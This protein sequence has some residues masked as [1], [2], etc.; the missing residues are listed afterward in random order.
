MEWFE[1][2]DKGVIS[3][4]PSSPI[5]LIN[6]VGAMERVGMNPDEWFEVLEAGAENQRKK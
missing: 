2:V 4:R 5:E 3:S 6:L 1:V